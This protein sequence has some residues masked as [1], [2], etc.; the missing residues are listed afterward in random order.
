MTRQEQVLARL[1]QANGEWVDG[2]ELAN[3][4]VGGSEGL[5]RLRE[6][7]QAGAPI[8]ERAHPDP[9]RSIWQY[10]LV[11]PQRGPRC[12]VCGEPPYKGETTATASPQVCYGYCAN[13]ADHRYFR[14][15]A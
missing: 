4:R 6:L 13:C 14:S 5:K 1:T 11:T 3:E 9:D 7:R 10:R 15:R 12:F 8:E 2:T